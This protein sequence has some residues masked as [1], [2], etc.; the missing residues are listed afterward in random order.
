M[1]SPATLTVHGVLM[2]ICGLGVLI[3]GPSG[4][5]K[6]EL[7]LELISRGHRLIA[8]DAPQISVSTSNSL[9]GN[10]PP[11]LRN[12]LEVRGLG[13]LN[14]AALFGEQAVA[15]NTPLQL[16]VTLETIA[17]S[18]ISERDITGSM[19]TTRRLLDVDIPEIRLALRGRSRHP[20]S[21]D[22]SRTLRYRSSL[23]VTGRPT[24]LL[25]ETLVKNFK[26]Q[27]QG[28]FAHAD[29]SKRQRRVM[30]SS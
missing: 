8:D 18:E 22:I 4:I 3:R 9:S 17:E 25:V 7:A 10:C 23:Y 2:E 27:Q 21:R 1:P 15:S 16:I 28:Y 24:A 5:G 20:A 30:D 12:L 6:G 29:L 19:H 14:V 11:L 13:V 26:L